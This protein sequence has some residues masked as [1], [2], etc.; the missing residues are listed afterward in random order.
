MLFIPTN[1]IGY[2]LGSLGTNLVK[3]IYTSEHLKQL[4]HDAISN[5]NFLSNSS[6]AINRQKFSMLRIKR[7][8]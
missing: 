5:L 7:F 2:L 8:L 3:R 4:H 1:T 6:S